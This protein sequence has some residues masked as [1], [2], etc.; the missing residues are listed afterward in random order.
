M[1]ML[2]LAPILI[3]LFGTLPAVADSWARPQT[4]EVFS[5]SREYFARVIPGESLG[6]TFGFAGAKTGRYASAE[7]YRRSADRSYKLIAEFPLPHPVAP[8]AFFVSDHGRLA[9]IDNWHNLG[10]GKVV[11][12]FDPRGRLVRSYELADLFLKEEIEAFP[13]SVSSIHWREGPLYVRQDQTT[14]LVT[15]RSGADFL[16]GLASGAFK[17]C[18]PHEGT[19]RCRNANTPRIWATG[20]AIQIER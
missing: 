4:T 15:V 12:I 1:S 10:Y 19:F 5:A 6:D 9:T 13:R 16:F 20:N 2:R 17:Y 7:L 3:V 8:V 14:L 11:A 18:E